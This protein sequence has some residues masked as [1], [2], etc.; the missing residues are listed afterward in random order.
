MTKA[1]RT[2]EIDR[3][4]WR[5]GADSTKNGTGLG[6]TGLQNEEGFLCCLGFVCKS[7]KAKVKGLAT[8]GDGARHVPLLTSKDVCWGGIS[9]SDLSHEAMCINDN[10]K[11]TRQ[12]KEKKLK[13]LFKGKLRLV[14]KGRS[15]KF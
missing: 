11:T 9:D 1:I 12:D 4:K 15:V 14:F 3:S 5:T 10:T 13:K 2:V 6:F 8:P 7:H